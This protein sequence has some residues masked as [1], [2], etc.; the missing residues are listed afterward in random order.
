MDTRVLD[1]ILQLNPV[2]FQ[3]NEKYTQRYPDSGL[4]RVH[5]GF[6]AQEIQKV[7]PEMVSEM[8]ESPDSVNYLDLDISHLQVYM[9]KAMQEQG[10]VLE[11]VVYLELLRRGYKV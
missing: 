2:S 10:H 4:E 1:K 11:N 6:I 7:F 9:V 8:K 3:Y 5:K